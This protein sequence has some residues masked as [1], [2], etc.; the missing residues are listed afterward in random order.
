MRGGAAAVRSRGCSPAETLRSRG[1]TSVQGRRG[2]RLGCPSSDIGWALA[3]GA[4]GRGCAPNTNGSP[5][6]CEK[7]RQTERVALR[8]G[9]GQAGKREE[10]TGLELVSLRGWPKGQT[11]VVSAAR[12]SRLARVGYF[13]ARAA[14]GVGYLSCVA[15]AYNRSTQ[16]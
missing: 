7:E 4:C 12:P 14:L 9:R 13:A 15:D 10:T 8:N 3:W 11:P 6:P 16:S 1:L 2:A 5:V